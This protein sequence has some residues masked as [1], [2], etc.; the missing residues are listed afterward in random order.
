[1]HIK[2][3]RNKFDKL[4]IIEKFFSISIVTFLSWS[5][6]YNFILLDSLFDLLLIEYAVKYA[7]IVLNIFDFETEVFFN[8]IS[9][10]ERKSVLIN[11][12]CNILN[13]FGIYIS[14]VFGYPNYITKKLIF[15]LIGFS[16]L[17]SL[18]VIRISIF[19]IVSAFMPE[20]WLI[21]HKYSSYIIF[22]PVILG[23]WLLIIKKS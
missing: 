20:F 13:V 21:I 4:S 12:A 15:S 22:Y 16:L 19:A 14:F 5:L 18:N 2:S 7:S 9:I 11:S 17:F 10:V 1:L 6:L 3:L 23:L 8:E